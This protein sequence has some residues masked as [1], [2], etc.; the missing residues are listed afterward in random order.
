MAG[1]A[2][3]TPL[4]LEQVL[5]PESVFQAGLLGVLLP[6][7]VDDV[8]AR[9]GDQAGHAFGPQGGGD[10]GGETAPVV[11]PFGPDDYAELHT[12]GSIVALV[13]SAGVERF[14]DTGRSAHSRPASLLEIR[15]LLARHPEGAAERWVV[16]RSSPGVKP[17]RFLNIR[18]KWAGSVMPHRLAVW[19]TGSSTAVEESSL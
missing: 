19:L 17:K 18:L 9:Q 3:A 5:V 12:E 1:A 4:R 2:F 15:R 8:V 16:R 7:D 11:P 14:N 10:A 6:F 13:T